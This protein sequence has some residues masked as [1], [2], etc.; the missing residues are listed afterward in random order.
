MPTHD[1]KK[2]AALLYGSL[3]RFISEATA[4]GDQRGVRMATGAARLEFAPDTLLGH[5]LR[6]HEA[7][8]GRIGCSREVAERIVEDVLTAARS[9]DPWHLSESCSAAYA[10]LRGFMGEGFMDRFPAAD[11]QV[12]TVAQALFDSVRRGPLVEAVADRAR[13]R[14]ALVRHVMSTEPP[15]AP[16]PDPDR[17]MLALKLAAEGFNR[18]YSA[19]LSPSQMEVLDAYV[20]GASKGDWTRYRRVSRARLDEAVGAISEFVKSERS[21]GVMTERLERLVAFAMGID[22]SSPES[23][24]DVLDTQ[25]VA[26]EV[27]R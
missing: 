5:E 4:A 20:V 8:A 24:R 9:V 12:A 14:E 27:L 3:I 19:S 10:N 15:P 25:S 11:P 1:R 7:V 13:M 22:T 17:N 2:N 18:Q 21:D 6:L 23:V 16:Q 26:A